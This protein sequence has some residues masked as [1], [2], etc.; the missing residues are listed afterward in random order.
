MLISILLTVSA[1][2]IS[3]LRNRGEKGEIWLNGTC[4]VNVATVECILDNLTVVP[5]CLTTGTPPTDNI[6][7]ENNTSQIQL[8]GN[9]MI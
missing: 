4:I 9:C 5:S 2:L 7:P 3:H 1:Y 8:P 6:M